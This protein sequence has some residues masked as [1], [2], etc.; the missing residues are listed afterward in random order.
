MKKY[1]VIDLQKTNFMGDTWSAP[2]SLNSLRSR[3]WAL[4]D[5]RTTKYK[6]FTADYIQEAWQ[7]EF[8]GAK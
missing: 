6:Y 1:S 4:D 5:A 3:F 2:E 8:E 7:V